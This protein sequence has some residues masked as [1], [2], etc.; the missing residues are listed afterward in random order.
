ML[1]ILEFICIV[2]IIQ[3]WLSATWTRYEG[4]QKFQLNRID[5]GFLHCVNSHQL[6][7]SF[8][9]SNTSAGTGLVARSSWIVWRF[10]L[11]TWLVEGEVPL[12]CGNCRIRQRAWR[13]R[14]D[15][16]EWKPAEHIQNWPD[17]TSN[18]CL[19]Y[20]YMCDCGDSARSLVFN[21]IKLK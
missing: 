19:C 10:V 15:S 8:H 17:S 13:G 3:R 4:R 5:I 21:R 2:W 1:E 9:S 20:M 11:A 18:H 7:F 12:R 6:F 14:A 16:R